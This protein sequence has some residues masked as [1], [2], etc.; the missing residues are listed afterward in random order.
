M[1]RR[2]ARIGT[3]IGAWQYR[4]LDGRLAS[5]SRDVHVLMITT[6]G[7]RTGLPRSTCV[8][9]VEY[10]GGYLV[11]GS[12][13][14]SPTSTSSTPRSPGTRVKSSGGTMPVPVR[15]RPER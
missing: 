9:Y 13:S 6:P 1:N 11:W 15:R 12:G 2:L 5:G 8:R 10:D 4:V 7:R 14:G 3:R